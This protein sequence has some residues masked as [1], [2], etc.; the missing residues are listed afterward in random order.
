MAITNE[1]S[2]G[3]YKRNWNDTDWVNFN[4]TNDCYRRSWDDNGWDK[5]SGDNGIVF[6]RNSSDTGWVQIY[7]KGIVVIPKPPPITSTSVSMSTKQRNHSGWNSGGSGFARQGWCVQSGAGGE[8]FGFIKIENKNLEGAGNIADVK[9]EEVRFSGKLGASGNYNDPQVISFRG[10]SLSQAS[11]DPF[12]TYDRNPP[13]TYSWEPTGAGSPIPIGPV[14]GDKGTLLRWMNNT[15]YNLCVYNGETS[16]TSNQRPN[17]SR[18]YLSIK[19]FNLQVGSYSYNA[20]NVVFSRP[21]RAPRF[22]SFAALASVPKDDNYLS[23]VVPEN[24]ANTLTAEQAI[25]MLENEE[26]SYVKDSELITLSESGITPRIM[27][28]ENGKIKV[29]HIHTEYTTVQYEDAKGLWQNCIC[30]SPLVYNLPV[31]VKHIRI[32]ERNEDRVFDD[33]IL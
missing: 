30:L 3:L 32:Y 7:P 27:S 12:T 13:F 17:W 23:L 4:D 5:G 9:F 29:S 31:G 22:F 16:G 10:T 6:R 8:Q 33:M 18:N 21:R 2:D 28:V 14:G 1:F 24:M 11:G 20:R 15:Y 25:K 26:L 19:E